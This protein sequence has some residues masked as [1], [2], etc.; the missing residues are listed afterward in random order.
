M[1][2]KEFVGIMDTTQLTYHLLKSVCEF[3]F[4]RTDR[5]SNERNRGQQIGQSI[6]IFH[7]VQW[8]GVR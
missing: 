1:L 2:Q 6:S 5:I 8:S 3:D 4:S 7:E